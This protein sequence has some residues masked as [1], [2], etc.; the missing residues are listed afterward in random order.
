MSEDM[1][2][3]ACIYIICAP[4]I[5]YI[6]RFAIHDMR[7]NEREGALLSLSDGQQ[8]RPEFPS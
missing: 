4:Y 3:K 1:P 8:E 6:I 2:H 5:P 7:R